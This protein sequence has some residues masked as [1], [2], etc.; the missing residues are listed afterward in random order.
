[1]AEADA[2]DLRDVVQVD[3]QPGGR[4]GGRE[5]EREGGREGGR[6]QV[7]KTWSLERENGKE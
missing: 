3:T 5:G 7:R 2:A 6:D 1:V 4:G